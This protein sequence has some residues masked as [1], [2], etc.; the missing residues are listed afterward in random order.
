MQR[1]QQ[2]R[3][4]RYGIG[5]CTGCV[6]DGDAIVSWHV[7]DACSTLGHARNRSLHPV[8]CCILHGAVAHVVLQ[9]V[10][11]LNITNCP[12]KLA[13]QTCHALVS[14]AAHARWPARRRS[15]PRS[16]CPVLVHLAQVVGKDKARAAAIGAMNN[17]DLLVGQMNAGVILGN[18]RITPRRNLAKVNIGK[19]LAAESK[20]VHSRYMEHRNNRTQHRWNV[21][22]LYLR[23]AQHIVGHGHVGGAEINGALGHL[24]DAAAGANRLVVDLNARMCRAVFSKP[25]RIN[26]IRECR[27]CP[28]QILGLG[29]AHSQHN[30]QNRNKS[31][32]HFT[33]PCSL[34]CRYPLS[35]SNVTGI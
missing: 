8:A 26:R 4:A 9:S 3:E 28:G 16:T 7:L 29:C 1:N 14:L 21:H 12:G 13:H 27:T 17:D 11:Q 20:V 2:V 19:R 10:N 34:H 18:R 22:Q 31:L 25:L 23:R 33:L 6:G 35:R 30:E 5:F 32:F 24:A 15:L